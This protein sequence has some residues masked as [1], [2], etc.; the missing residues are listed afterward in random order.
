MV[1]PV[2]S[3]A[4]WLRE[5]QVPC[6]IGI[7][8]HERSHEQLLT[9]HVRL[10]LDLSVAART[11]E[12]RQTVDYA[13]VAGEVTALLQFRRYRLLEVAS[14]E[15]AAMLL[16]VHRQ[17]SGV[18]IELVKQQALDSGSPA[19]VIERRAVGPRQV[20]AEPGVLRATE[21]A[22]LEVVAVGPGASVTT[23]QGERIEWIVT[24]ELLRDGE[25]TREDVWSPIVAGT[26]A[27]IT[28][29]NRRSQNACVFRC[30][31]NVSRG[32]PKV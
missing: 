8:P 21:L 30:V 29:H 23:S 3:D 25:V 4:I 31:H 6:I 18:S 5:L 12:L 17:L 16:G 26:H 11:G 22:T 14:E 24:G 9:V 10:E 28:Y 2:P 20:A 1:R 32:E 27:Q 15:I 19:V 13:R 7:F